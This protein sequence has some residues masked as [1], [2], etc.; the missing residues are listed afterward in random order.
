MYAS[1]IRKFLWSPRT[2]FGF[3]RCKVLILA[4]FRGDAIS[5]IEYLLGDTET[6]YNKERYEK[7]FCNEERLMDDDFRIGIS[8]SIK[9]AIKLH[10]NF[11]KSDIIVA[12]PLGL[13]LITGVEG[14]QKREY[15][16]LS[17]LEILV[18]DRASAILMQNW[19]HLETIL[20]LSNRLPEH[21]YITQ[22]LTQIR[23]Y[24]F[25]NMSKF[26][27]QTIVYTNHYF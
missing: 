21:K 4:P 12:S 26:Y 9:G 8:F 22:E 18:L 7:E 10:A 11:D 25:E 14:E 3:T 27:R 13:R 16:F 1:H 15:H 23:P 2:T 6:V 5:I 19:E 20:D 24:F 17:S